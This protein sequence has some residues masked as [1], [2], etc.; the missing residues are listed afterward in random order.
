M[1]I[2]GEA[3]LLPPPAAGDGVTRPA[4]ADAPAPDEAAVDPSVAEAE[5]PPTAEEELRNNWSPFYTIH[6]D[7]RLDGLGFPGGGSMGTRVIVEGQRIG[8]AGGFSGVFTQPESGSLVGRGLLDLHLAFAPIS[9]ERGRLRLELGLGALFSSCLNSA[10]PDVGLSGEV[11]LIG[12]FG[13][14]G[15]VHGVFWPYSAVDWHAA[16]QL[17]LGMYQIRAGARQVFIDDQGRVDGV[18]HTV[19]LV[20]PWL[21]VGIRL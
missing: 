18:R 5:V 12:P 19:S 13:L 16:L 17:S 20:G 1:A 11:R 4:P 3:L 10:G 2:A 9:G 21:G 6:G 15:G 14:E 8:F 7:L